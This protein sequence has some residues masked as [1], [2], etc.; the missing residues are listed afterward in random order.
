M[1][2]IKP[3]AHDDVL[4]SHTLPGIADLGTTVVSFVRLDNATARIGHFDSNDDLLKFTSSSKNPGYIMGN[5]V[6]LKIVYEDK[7]IMI[8]ILDPSLTPNQLVS[9]ARE[10]GL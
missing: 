2:Y 8:V 7:G 5:N 4:D 6:Q 10:L 1:V 9:M 3:D